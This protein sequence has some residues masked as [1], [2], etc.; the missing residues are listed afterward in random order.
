MNDDI[1]EI[2]DNL[3]DEVWSKTGADSYDKLLDYITN[4]QQENERLDTHLG[5]LQNAIDNIAEHYNL[6]VI[7][8]LDDPLYQSYWYSTHLDS[9][10]SAGTHPSVMLYPAIA[11][12]NLRLFAKCVQNYDTYFMDLNYTTDLNP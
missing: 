5:E 6:P 4:L 12:A 9:A 3:K 2:L 8:A 11:K 7:D 10:V 1:K